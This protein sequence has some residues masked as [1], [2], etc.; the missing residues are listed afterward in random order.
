MTKADIVERIAEKAEFSKKDSIELVEC[1]FETMKD[2]L[3]SG[4]NL[5]ISGFGNFVVKQKSARRGRNPQT[6]EEMT[7]TARHILT[8]KPST[9]LKAK[10]NR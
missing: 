3:S 8:F 2:T 5:K 7:I 10:I 6:G 9:M 4:G 1:V